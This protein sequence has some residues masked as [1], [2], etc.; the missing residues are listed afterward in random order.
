M[1]TAEWKRAVRGLLPADMPWGFRGSLCYRLPVNRVLLGVLGEGSGFDKGVYIWRVSMPLF[2]PSRNVVLSW[3]ERIGGG[4]RK[5]DR[6]DEQSLAGAIAIAVEGL[7]DE[8]E[9]L[10]QVVAR[11]DLA[12]P[13]R[14]LHEA[15][16]YARLLLGDLVAAQESLKRAAA[17]VPEAMWGQEIIERAHLIGRLLEQG[18]RERAVGQLDSW[19]DQTA[20]ALG[21]GRSAAR[22]V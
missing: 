21:L 12:S 2:V 14:H 19:C 16:G 18:D 22:E 20:A 13:N 4:A 17:G 9:A 1:K 7:G 8:E 15:G 11:D 10:E 6:F 3:S 5:Y